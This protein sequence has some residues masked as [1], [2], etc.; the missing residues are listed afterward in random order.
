MQVTKIDRREIKVLPDEVLC[1]VG[2]KNE[3][4]R[5]PY[6]LEYYRK[7]GVDRFFFMDNGSTDGSTEYLLAQED[8][9]CFHTEGS[10]FALNVD[11]PNWLNAMLNVY[12]DGNW[13]VAV[14][15]DELLVYPGSE[16][17]SLQRFCGF[18][19]DTGADAMAGFMIDMYGDG[20]VANHS[21]RQGQPFLEA[22]YFFDPKP[23]W[24]RPFN[25]GYPRF[26]MFGGVRERVFWHGRFRK[27]RPPCLSKVPLVRWQ[28]GKR[29][30]VAQHM[31]NS[32]NLTPVLGALLHF[33]FLAGFQLRVS[34]E[35]DEN[36]DVEEKGL[37]ERTAYIDAL[38]RQPDLSLRNSDS[39]R[40]TGS[41]QLLE[42]GWL[43]SSPAYK[44]FLT[45]T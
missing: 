40:Y 13:C 15:C 3:G 25:G 2:V 16:H 17:V 20:P 4:P 27:M 19:Q 34:G 1:V 37:K 36:R 9:Y 32:A 43:K 23:G 12:C 38:T 11:P 5:I 21:Y 41:G 7:L 29:Y 33:K 39:V 22:N 31:I 26:Q 8:C 30:L 14:D 35:V 6:F 18:L 42:L 10:H 28:R 45:R 44:D 24:L